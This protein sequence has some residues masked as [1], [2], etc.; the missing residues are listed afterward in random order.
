MFKV[1]KLP[2]HVTELIAN[3]YTYKF[4]K[5]LMMYKSIEL[6]QHRN[7]ISIRL[8]L[9]SNDDNKLLVKYRYF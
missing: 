5:N 1:N 7:V 6:T 9:K 8:N 3:E 4:S 2:W